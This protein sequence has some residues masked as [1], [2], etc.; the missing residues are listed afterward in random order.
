MDPW[1][2][3]H[4]VGEQLLCFCRRLES[5]YHQAHGS[6]ICLLFEDCACLG[7]YVIFLQLEIN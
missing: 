1:R 4:L 6:Y 3:S 2:L 5:Y 7:L